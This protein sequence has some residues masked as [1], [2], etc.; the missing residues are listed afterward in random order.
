MELEK[1]KNN[2][3]SNEWKQTF[4][5][6]VDYL[7]NLEKNL[8][9]Q[10]KSTNSRIDNLVLHSGGDSPNEV[11]D[12]RVNNRGE[13]FETLQ[14]RLKAHEDQSDE[15]IS[16]LSND[17]SN[18][19]EELDQLNSS[20][21]QIIGGYNEPIDIY[22]SKN[23]SD[24][25]GDGTEEKPYA[26]IQTAVNTIP[27]ITTAPIT[28]WI[29]DG[30]YLEDVVING[31][32]YRSLMI[33]PIN[34]I[35]NINPLTSDL[36][37]RVRSLATTTCV[38]YTQISGIQIVDTVNAPIDPSGNRYGIMNEQSG[39]MAINKCKFSENTK[40][41]GY[42]AIYVGG[43]SKLN[44]YGNTTFINQDVALRVRLM[45]EALAGLTGSGN[46][47]GI[48]CEDA[49]VRGTA[50]TAFATTPTS[51]SGNGLIIS[52]GQVLS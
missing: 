20:V 18:Q 1:L 16:Q 52:R 35:S 13:T 14:A 26:T 37:V 28:I 11:V 10:H 6:N 7:E 33:K 25:T 29:D 30:A 39:Y 47:I 9:E 21:Q 41:L 31:L 48:K 40:S 50:S 51:I 46:N 34:D 5:D 12:A 22:V 4:N 2:R 19:K 3:I 17:A 36:P 32:S 27:L 23:G 8:D 49:T 45:S 38:G 43:V 42:N 44:M 15:E 24:Q